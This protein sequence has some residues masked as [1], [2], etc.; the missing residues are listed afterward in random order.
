MVR[1]LKLLFGLLDATRRGG[2]IANFFTRGLLETA[3]N[4]RY[5]TRVDTAEAFEAF[6]AHSFRNDKR[7]V[8]V[9]DRNIAERDGTVLPIE[10][11]IL[12]SI[13]RTLERSGLTLSEVPSRA[14]DKWPDFETRLRTLGIEESYAGM[15]GGPSSYVHGTWH[16]LLFYNLTDVSGGFEL[17]TSWATIRPEP[18]LAL[19]VVIATAAAEYV[20]YLLA[21]FVDAGDLDARL[22]NCLTK[23]RRIDELHEGFVTKR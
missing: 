7:L 17:D 10:R 11:R 23:A 8:G 18:L 3:I 4:I 1:V 13:H 6:V 19:V 20:D 12:D 2:E 9:I 14:D 5:L 15:F 22:R 16:E 21:D